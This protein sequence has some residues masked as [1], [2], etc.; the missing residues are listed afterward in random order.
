MDSITDLREFVF[1]SHK[2]SVNCPSVA[3]QGNKV[4][5][6]IL[7][8]LQNPPKR[9]ARGLN[10][11]T[12]KSFVS[13]LEDETT[14]HGKKVLDI[15]L[16]YS[17]RSEFN[18]YQA[19]DGNGRLPVQSFDAAIYAAIEDEVDILNISAGEPWEGPIDAWPITKPVRDAIDA[20][21]TIVAAAGND[22]AEPSVQPINC[23][24]AIEDVIAVGGFE[25]LCEGDADHPDGAYWAQKVDNPEEEEYPDIIAEGVY[26]G[27]QGCGSTDCIKTQC[28]QP[29][30]GNPQPTNGKPDVVAPVH[31]PNTSHKGNP[32]LEVGTSF[33]SPI[34]AGS[35]GLI[36]GELIE[37]RIEIPPPQEIREIILDT[38][39]PIDR[40]NYRKLNVT[41]SLD[42]LL[43]K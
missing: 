17:P 23:P 43:S 33:A 42:T 24:A 4:R 41:R 19:V 21:I 8:S 13:S 12:R 28:E 6:G 39:S 25:V 26:C 29:W 36:F 18:F 22:P 3:N 11:G 15:L 31:L 38:S 32:F 40:G 10:I 30:I 16:K 20:G 5:I 7:D 9:I 27:Q 37:E 1:D 34:V 14:S 2:I 35:L